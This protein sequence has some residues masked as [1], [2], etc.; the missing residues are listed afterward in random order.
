MVFNPGMAPKQLALL[1]VRSELADQRAFFGVDEELFELGPHVL[2]GLTVAGGAGAVSAHQ[3][4][5]AGHRC[6]LHRAAVRQWRHR[7]ARQ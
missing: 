6:A 7:Q 5:S 1:L 2:H 3:R 4:L